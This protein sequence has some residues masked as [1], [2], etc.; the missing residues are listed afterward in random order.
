MTRPEG[1]GRLDSFPSSLW[2]RFWEN[3]RGSRERSGLV[4]AAPP[5]TSAAAPHLGRQASVAAAVT[6][7]RLDFP[8][9]RIDDLLRDVP[10][11]IIVVVE[12][13]AERATPVGQ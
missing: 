1:S 13:R 10:G 9:V 4:G 6:V 2:T 7:G 3:G 12:D 11:D 8:A 5:R